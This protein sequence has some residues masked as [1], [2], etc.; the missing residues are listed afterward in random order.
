MPEKEDKKPNLAL[1]NEVFIK[2][3]RRL[4]PGIKWTEEK[5]M[6][7]EKISTDDGA[8]TFY[9]FSL[10]KTTVVVEWRAKTG[11]GISYSRDTVYAKDPLSVIMNP[12]LAAKKVAEMLGANEVVGYLE[13]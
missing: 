3:V 2:E 9:T 10:I 11:F 12:Y 13:T 4:M 7:K 8:G 5:P 6:L 1:Q